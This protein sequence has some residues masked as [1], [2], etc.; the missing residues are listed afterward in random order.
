MKI[1]LKKGFVKPDDFYGEDEYL[2]KKLQE[3]E[4][5]EITQILSTLE[6][7]S[8]NLNENRT[9]PQFDLR[10]KFRYIDP[11]YSSNGIFRTLSET[12]QNYRDFL[13]EQR[14]INKC[15][16]KFDLLI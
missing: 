3:S 13:E 14:E 16:I 7:P 6:S 8:L 2:I 5:P 10:K 1:G 11:H 12:D 4:N 15:G 9:N